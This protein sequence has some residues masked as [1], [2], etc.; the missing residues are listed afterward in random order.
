MGFDHKKI[1]THYMTLAE[2]L[3]NDEVTVEELQQDI[4]RDVNFFK[5]LYDKGINSPTAYY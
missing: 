1:T 2:K 4:R 5:D 3:V